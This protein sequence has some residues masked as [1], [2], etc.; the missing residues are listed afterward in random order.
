LTDKGTSTGNVAGVF[1]GSLPGGAPVPNDY[2]LQVQVK[3]NPSSRSVFGIFFRVQTGANHQG[4]YSFLI[5][6]SGY[7]N[8][9]TYDDPTGQATSL[10]G[11]PGIALNAN[12]FTTIDI[13]VQGSN[14]M[15]YYNGAKQGGISS[16]NYSTGSLGLAADVGTDVSF[17]NF[18]LYALP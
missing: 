1:L 5:Q 13:I 3:V 2:V 9:Y 10:F 4:K 16:G 15:I 14:F 11:R 8:G 17:K 12:G 7:W 18:A 6:T